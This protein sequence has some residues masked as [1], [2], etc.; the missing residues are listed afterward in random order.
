MG[1]ISAVTVLVAASFML[2]MFQRAILQERVGTALQ[3]RDLN[4]KEIVGLVPWVILIFLMGIYPDPFIDKFEPTVTH[5]I[6]DIL[7]I[8]AMK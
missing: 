1:Y 2:W 4:I 6:N 3:M 5:Y 7:K 8:G